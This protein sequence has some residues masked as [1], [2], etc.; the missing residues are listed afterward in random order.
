M[1]RTTTKLAA[2]A[3]ALLSASA[4]VAQP[5]AGDDADSIRTY[6]LGE[7]SV[8]GDSVRDITTATVQQIPAAR[9]SR[10]DAATVAGLV[11]QIPS[12][13]IQTNSRGEALVYLRA[14]AERQV[15]LF[16]DGALMNVPW[17]NRLDMSM[18]PSG[19]IGGITVS[20]G[21]PSVLY[22]AN[23]LGGTINMV[24]VDRD[25][26]GSHSEIQTQAGSSGL[27]GGSI[28]HTG[29][30]GSLTYIGEA[31]Y[32]TREGFALPRE[33]SLTYHQ[34]SDALRTNSDIRS[35]N[36]YLRAENRFSE[37]VEVGAAVHF[38]DAEKGVA[39]EGHIEGARFWRYPTWQG[40][41]LSLNSEALF[42][43]DDEWSF[44]GAAWG[45]RFAQD[46]AQYEDAAY[47]T[48][49]AMEEDRDITIGTRLILSR[50]HDGGRVSLAVNGLSSV[51]D[52][53]DLAYDSTGSLIEL[54]D[55]G[56]AV[57]PYPTATYEQ[58]IYS[59]GVEAE[60]RFGAANVTLGASFD[61]MRT[62]RTGDKPA[63]QP[64][65][66]FSLIGGVSYDLSEGMALRVSGGRK[67]R[68][69]TMRELYG[70]ALR[71][72]LINPELK[73]E[74]TW[75]GE[76]GAEA[77]GEAGSLAI[78]GFLYDSRNTIDQRT[79]DTL[80]G[81]KRQRINLP[82][83]SSLGAELSGTLRALAPLRVDGHFT[84]VHARGRTTGSNGADSTFFLTEKPETISTVTAEYT[85][86]FGLLPSIEIVHTGLAYSPN[87]E[88]EM[89]RLEPSTV[90]N[91]R[92]AYR[93]SLWE[94][95]L[96]QVY[97]R[98]NNLTDALVQPQLGLPAAGREV[99]AG[100]KLSF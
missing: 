11:Y 40:L 96:A 86:G 58:M 85:F 49:S 19:A 35:L 2:L 30:T 75:V 77:R 51:H 3:A 5:A 48:L 98:V 73:P 72:F 44:R 55:D 74:E 28:L 18:L 59:T 33:A 99:L 82:G 29:R 9:L 84:Y 95:S 4:A 60:H 76:L 8:H 69:P 62:P 80:G 38:V 15:A 52:Q 67:T 64:F 1:T 26:E 20:K 97:A 81:R 21:A 70:E 78:V 7:V 45:S 41:T 89:V 79:F 34:S 56:G 12:A 16:F 23:T 71:R 68:F 83:S 24:S 46:I 90:L 43:A 100:L 14:A 32:T 61:G 92:L 57:M 53:R 17:D 88:D 54:R 93:F 50:A 65:G 91:A 25:A 47:G 39:P 31:G 36:A 42:G 10:T 94:S 27:F 37:S 22:G 13:R 6:S 87:D 63:Q 66:D